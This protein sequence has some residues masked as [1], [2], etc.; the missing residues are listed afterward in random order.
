MH[1][2]SGAS[3][4]QDKRQSGLDT[5]D[6]VYGEGFSARISPPGT[7]FLEETVTHLFAD[8]WARPGLSIRDRRLLV[9]GATAALGRSDLIRIQATGAL[10]NGELSETEL[11]EAVLQLAYYVGWGN[12]TEVSAGVQ[13]ALEAHRSSARSQPTERPING[14]TE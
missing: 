7:P 11:N 9:I 6:A 13:S 12:A 2:P 1:D 5:M 14:E 4:A 3:R 10:T 8:V